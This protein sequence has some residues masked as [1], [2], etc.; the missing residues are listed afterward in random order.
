L[1]CRTHG[2]HQMAK[3]IRNLIDKYGAETLK[4]MIDDIVRADADYDNLK[5]LCAD[6]AQ[7]SRWFRNWAEKHNLTV[8]ETYG[9]R[10]LDIEELPLTGPYVVLWLADNGEEAH[11]EL[12]E[13]LEKLWWADGMNDLTIKLDRILAMREEETV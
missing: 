5:A 2:E 1:P 13:S 8:K 11:F 7:A 9:G 6:D 3:Q 10:R 12:G 4:T